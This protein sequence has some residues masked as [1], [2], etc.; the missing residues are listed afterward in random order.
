MPGLISLCVF[1]TGLPSLFFSMSAEEKRQPMFVFLGGPGE[2][3]N[4][5]LFGLAQAAPGQEGGV[6]ARLPP[7]SRPCSV[8]RLAL[9]AVGQ[10]LC[11]KSR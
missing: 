5:E 1:E 3:E 11:S 4:L 10:K 2:N 9:C 7:V 8:P 6:P